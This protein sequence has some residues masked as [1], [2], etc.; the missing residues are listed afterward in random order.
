MKKLLVTGCNGF[1][2]GGVIAQAGP[3]WEVHGAGRG[4]L[5]ATAGKLRYHQVDLLQSQ[6]VERIFQENLFDSVIHTAAIAN[7]DYCEKHKGEAVENNVNVTENITQLCEKFDVKFVYCS[8]D[9]VFDG[10]AGR[11]SE[12]DAPNPINHYG[13]TKVLAEQIVQSASMQWVVARLSLVVGLP[14]GGRGNSYLSGLIQRLENGENDFSPENEIR[15]PIDVKSLSRALIELAENDF[16]GIVHLAGNS[17]VNRYEMARRIARTLRL[18]SEFII[19]TDSNA[20]AG[21]APRP[22]DVSLD[23]STAR[24]ELATPMLDLEEALAGILGTGT[25]SGN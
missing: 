3:G 7:I 13:V 4:R 18:R 19:S 14:V 20:I 23:N 11:Y 8:T 5:R 25:D 15:T 22:D 21:R 1:V 17:R 10:Q 9:N 24:R 12:E 6:E 2:A 16:S